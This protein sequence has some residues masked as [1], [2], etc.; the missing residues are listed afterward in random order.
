MKFCDEGEPEE[1]GM[2][3]FLI[4][5]VDGL[6]TLGEANVENIARPSLFFTDGLV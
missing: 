2:C 4:L 1:T 6:E 3:R 5:D